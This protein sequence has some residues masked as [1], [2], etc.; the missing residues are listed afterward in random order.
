[1]QAV[2]DDPDRAATAYEAFGRPT[3]VEQ[4]FS[5][6]MAVDLVV[7]RWDL[8]RAAGVDTAIPA[9]DV[10][11]ARSFTER[12]GDLARTSGAFGPALPEPADADEQTRLLA[13]LGRRAG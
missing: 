2:L 7:H 12:M 8:A 4:T 10:A 11:F 6:F 5:T 13:L 3:T 9:Q 1:M